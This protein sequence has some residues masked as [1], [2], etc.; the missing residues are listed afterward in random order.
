VP[1]GILHRSEERLQL[2]QRDRTLWVW[3][4]RLWP[5]WRDSLAIV[6]PTTVIHWH[7]EGFKLYWRGSAVCVGGG[8][9]GGDV[10]AGGGALGDARPPGSATDVSGLR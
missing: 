1:R 8:R 9:D 6:K 4:S 10:S 3:F 5:D 2:R 7:R